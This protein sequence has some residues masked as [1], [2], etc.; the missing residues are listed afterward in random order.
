MWDPTALMLGVAGGG[1]P[2][3]DRA[4]AWWS[5]GH[6]ALSCW[7]KGPCSP[8]ECLPDCSA[9]EQISCTLLSAF[10]EWSK[11]G[12]APVC[13]CIT[14]TLVVAMAGQEPVISACSTFQGLVPPAHRQAWLLGVL[15][16]PVCPS[17][18]FSS[19][20]AGNTAPGEWRDRDWEPWPGPWGAAIQAPGRELP[21]QPISALTP[22]CSL[23]DGSLH[24][25]LICKV[26]VPH[27]GD[28]CQGRPPCQCRWQSLGS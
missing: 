24:K 16:P 12:L 7:V 27:R 22:F 3:V 10:L 1:D 6:P 11:S 17:T 5:C 21:G 2:L 8:Q 25:H 15:L 13:H 23:L 26:S 4:G 14:S 28:P 20:C 19:C 9:V 18:C